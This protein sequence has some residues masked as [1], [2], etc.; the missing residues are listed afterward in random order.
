MTDIVNNESDTNKI[1]RLSKL[2]IVATP[3]GN[4]NDLSYRA[5]TI[6]ES[7]DIVVCEDTRQT[8][9][10]L[11]S[12][13]LKKSML[14]YNDH[15]DAND[16]DKILSLLRQGKNIALV[17]D[18]GTPLISDPGYKLVKAVIAEGFEVT[19]IPGPCAAIAAL[20]ISALPSDEFYFAGFLPAKQQ[21]RVNFLAKF[22][23]H[24]TTLIF[25]DTARNLLESLSDLAT[26]FGEQQVAICRELTKK[27]EEVIRGS[28][29]EVKVKLLNREI[30]GEVIIVLYNDLTEKYNLSDIDIYIAKMLPAM[31][32]KDIAEI[33]ADLTALP[34]KTIYNRAIELKDDQEKA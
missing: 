20:T 11:A 17:S 3:I 10:L 15:S 14:I 1:N 30:L 12:H 9:R 7:V 13:G 4:S 28:L 31:H 34:K 25:Y 33:L 6:L 19:S 18:A 5:K 24:A 22:K 26:V 32:V 8:D 21:A 29:S 16:R 27:F 2:Y 23:N